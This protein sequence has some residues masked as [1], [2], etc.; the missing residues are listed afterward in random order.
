MSI[1]QPECVFVTSAIQ[2]AMRMRYIAIYGLTIST[3]CLHI[4]SS[5][6]PFSKR[7][8]ERKKEK[9]RKKGKRNFIEPKVCILALCITFVWNIIHSKK[10]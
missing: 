5:M 9:K 3:I 2:H 10:N 4:V 1:T 6:V 8:K 7:K